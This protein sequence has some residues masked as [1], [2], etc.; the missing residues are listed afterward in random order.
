[1][2]YVPDWERLSDA[3][4]RVM[5]AGLSKPEAQ[6]DICRAI[7]DRKI[8]I[9]LQAAKAEIPEAKWSGP[10]VGSH[11]A[12][13]QDL[14]PRD[15]DWRKSLP[16]RPWQHGDHPFVRV[17][18]ALIELFSAHVTLV[19]CAGSRVPERSTNG[20]SR[21]RTKRS[22]GEV[23][24]RH[25]GEPF[26]PVP[27]V[28]AWIAFRNPRMIE[29]NWKAAIQYNTSPIG[30]ALEDRHPQSALLRA[31]QDGS[32]PALRDGNQLGREKWANATGR[33]WPDDLR[34]R[35][36]DVLALWP[37]ERE[38]NPNHT[39][40]RNLAERLP[41][42]RHPAEAGTP[43]PAS[44]TV[45]SA[46]DLANDISKQTR[47]WRANRID[48]FTVRQRRVRA[49]IN[50]AE[51]ADWCSEVE[52][53]VVPNEAARASAYEKLQRDLMEGDFEEN[54]HSRVLYLHPWNVKAKMKRQWM[55]NII[56]IYPPA[57]IRS[58]YLDH[59][60]LP[61]NLFQRWL[62][63]HH[64]P[65]SAPRFQPTELSRVCFDRRRRERC[66]QGARFAS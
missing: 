4:S 25:F 23:A 41:P 33:R 49:W 29:T 28:L 31:L 58:Q 62:A 37:A 39:H 50:F 6:R 27:R 18:L 57:T 30:Q 51:I 19:L 36:E 2:A 20:N 54:D 5:A 3:L 60:W 35:R 13:P 9:R 10:V 56:E 26:W 42:A 45:K 34:F 65:G 22:R 63:K 8:R 16:K 17:H 44:I 52:G 43:D 32:L 21:A 40:E 64:L 1:M 48:R 38:Q 53:S 15:F 55:E 7:V 66:N 59:C 24:T 46:R 11:V 47:I 12:I 61:R 14:S